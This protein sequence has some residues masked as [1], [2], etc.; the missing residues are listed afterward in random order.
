M[1]VDE[2]HRLKVLFDRLADLPQPERS[3]GLDRE[4]TLSEATRQHLRAL[5]DFDIALK[6]MTARQAVIPP[7]QNPAQWIGC[8]VG[9]FVVESE[10]GVGGMGSVFLA[11]RAD[12]SV[13]QR[14]ALKLIRP[15]RLDE[16]TL[17]RFR[18]ERQ[19]MALL[20]HQNIAALHD[21]ANSTTVRPMW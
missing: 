12:G 17:A 8:R 5:L 19:V 10:L 11:H 16:H 14:V 20:K 18:L 1:E 7:L 13:E 21:L 3:A 4:I 2:F 15:E 6:D 9:A